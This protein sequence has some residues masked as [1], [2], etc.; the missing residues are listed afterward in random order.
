MDLTP[1]E[2]SRF[3]TLDIEPSGRRIQVSEETSLLEAM[4][5]AGIDLVA[6]C[7][8]AGFC[9]TCLIKVIQG[10]V[11]PISQIESQALDRTQIDQHLRLACQTRLLG[12]A[13]IFIPAESMIGSQQLQIEGTGS[14]FVFRPAVEVIKLQMDAP[15][16]DD[17]RADMTRVDDALREKGYSPLDLSPKVVA[18]LS[19]YLREHDWKCR[20]AVTRQAAAT[21]VSACLEPD[22]PV[23]GIAMD[24]GSTKIA[25]YLVN[26]EN[27]STLT[28]RGVMNPQIAYGED[29]VSRIAFANQKAENRT[30]LQKILV[31]SINQAI[32]E[33]CSEYRVKV[34]DIC[35]AVA[36]GNTAIHHFFCGLPVEQLGRAPYVPAVQLAQRFHA[37]E[38]GLKIAPFAAIYLPPNIA[39]YVG[40][41][42]VSALTVTHAFDQDE[43][44]ILVDIGTNTEISLIHGG[45]IY[46][47]SC[48]SGPAFEGAHIRN[49]VRAVPGAIEKVR[50]EGD[51]LEIM[52]IGNMPA[53]GLCG[54][55]TLS[56][57]AEMCSQGVIDRRGVIQKGKSREFE[58]VSAENSATGRAIVITRKDINEIQLAK[59]AIRAGIEVLLRH[60]CVEA[61][62]V[63]QWIIAGA[64]GTH[65]DL[66][67]AIRIGMFPAQP[68]DR[69]KQVGNAAGIGARQM[70]LSTVQREM[71]SSF[72][73]RE[74]YIELTAEKDFQE[75][76]V[77]SLLFPPQPEA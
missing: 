48:A 55:G 44:T 38:I 59:G 40:A 36:V 1:K 19:T 62:Q 32:N 73:D 27:G 77:E 53:I 30:F 39:G 9:D 33:M 22:E 13:K 28:T 64:F 2:N 17:L 51:K 25:L 21:A 26:L 10:S 54:S 50:L 6:S 66:N 4:Q 72:E 46:S 60:A 5:K 24:I 37:S 15:A 63:K 43:T 18:A 74:H 76:Y 41:D 35:E 31:E 8:G 56:V 75:I 65:L 7:G 42:H 34:E 45:Q 49:G 68:L 29:V 23:L 47:C 20:L 57:L 67:S 3:H 14:Q 69:F 61:A 70:L 71:A 16:L 52:T 12:D 11:T 58:L